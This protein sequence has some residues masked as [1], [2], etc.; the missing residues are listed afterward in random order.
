[1]SYGSSS[2][3]SSVYGGI[4]PAVITYTT[5][6]TIDSVLRKT[7]PAVFTI[8]CAIQKT[9]S[10]IFTIDSRILKSSVSSVS[11]D[12]VL[13]KSIYSTFTIDAILKAI[14]TFDIDAFIVYCR[15][16]TPEVVTEDETTGHIYRITD[17]VNW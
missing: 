1:M 13:Q 8:D 12:S 3:G 16:R 11:I 2:F 14:I 7:I 17:N 9:N 10:A 5:T 4:Y 15:S 6:V